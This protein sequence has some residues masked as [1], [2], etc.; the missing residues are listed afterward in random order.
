MNLSHKVIELAHRVE[1]LENTIRLLIDQRVQPSRTGALDIA[2]AVI[3]SNGRVGTLA[4]LFKVD[5]GNRLSIK[6]TSD[7]SIG[8]ASNYV[9]SVTD[10]NLVGLEYEYDLAQLRGD[11]TT[12]GITLTGVPCIHGFDSQQVLP[13]GAK[14]I[15]AHMPMAHYDETLKPYI[16]NYYY[17]PS[18]YT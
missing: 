4:D 17:M 11:D 12:T 9:Y 1:E 16:V 3:D 13:V 18:R 15:V 8:V 14:V 5:S 10:A 7:T 2:T 6:V